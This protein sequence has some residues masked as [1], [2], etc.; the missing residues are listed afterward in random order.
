MSIC[1]CCGSRLAAYVAWNRNGRCHHPRLRHQSRT[2]ASTTLEYL[3]THSP[4]SIHNLHCSRNVQCLRGGKVALFPIHRSIYASRSPLCQTL[5]PTYPA[6]RLPVTPCPF[7]PLPVQF[8]HPDIETRTSIPR[9]I[10]SIVFG[11]F[12]CSL[13]YYYVHI[14]TFSLYANVSKLDSL[15]CSFA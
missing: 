9:V 1:Q 6:Y 13:P 11:S 15:F 8:R 10:R 2:C 3:Y 14:Y 5:P 12:Q 7:Y 4:Y